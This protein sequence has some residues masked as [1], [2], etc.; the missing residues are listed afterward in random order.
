[1][2][3]E[4]ISQA[5]C[6]L[7][8]AAAEGFTTA[9]ELGLRRLSELYD[10]CKNVDAGTRYRFQ[11]VDAGDPTVLAWSEAGDLP[12]IHKTNSHASTTAAADAD[13][14]YFATCWVDRA[15]LALFE[16]EQ[17]RSMVAATAGVDGIGD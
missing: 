15:D 16:E 1:M 11:I 6:Q 5:P 13:N 17:S 10:P 14:V 3:R 12:E 9:R 2:C 7:T 8:P 4:V